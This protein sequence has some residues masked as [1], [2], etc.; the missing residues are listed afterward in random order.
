MGQCD[1]QTGH[2]LEGCCRVGN[3]LAVFVSRTRPRAFKSKRLQA[4]R[5][6]SFAVMDRSR[7]ETQDRSPRALVAGDEWPGKL[8]AESAKS[9]GV[10]LCVWCCWAIPAA[11]GSPALPDC[12][13]FLD[14]VCGSNWSVQAKRPQRGGH[15]RPIET[16]RRALGKMLTG[17]WL[18]LRS[19]S[20]DLRSLKAK[21]PRRLMS[22]TAENPP[23]VKIRCRPLLRPVQHL[24]DCDRC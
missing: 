12:G 15:L 2:R 3:V 5:F 14:Q 20:P 13:G 9:A 22:E 1:V 21:N 16:S 23:P 8:F 7:T 6:T 18:G 17:R 10:R 19:R 24:L 11:A 4:P